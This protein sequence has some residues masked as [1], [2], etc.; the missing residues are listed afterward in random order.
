[1]EVVSFLSLKILPSVEIPPFAPP[2]PIRTPF[3]P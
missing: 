1:V 3:A 2:A